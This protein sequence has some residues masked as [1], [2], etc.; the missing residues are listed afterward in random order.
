MPSLCRLAQ[1]SVAPLRAEHIGQIFSYAGKVGVRGA[2]EGSWEV[3]ER[4]API[5]WENG[6]SRTQTQTSGI[7][8]LGQLAPWNTNLIHVDSLPW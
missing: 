7:Q 3:V 2:P 8:W 6:S 5:L 4:E 1:L